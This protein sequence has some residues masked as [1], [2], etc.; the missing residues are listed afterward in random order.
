MW[1]DTPQLSC[2]FHGISLIY[3][4]MHTFYTTFYFDLQCD[5]IFEMDV[6]HKK[7]NETYLSI[8]NYV[9]V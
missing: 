8:Y 5:V 6:D 3:H 4:S 9:F 1:A 7:H 2:V